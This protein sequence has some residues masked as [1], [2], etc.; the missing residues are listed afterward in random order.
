MLS[1]VLSMIII[2][3]VNMTYK[4]I[5][6]SILYIYIITGKSLWCMTSIPVH[7]VWQINTF[8]Y[9]YLYHRSLTDQRKLAAVIQYISFDS[10]HILSNMYIP[11]GAL[12][13]CKDRCPVTFCITR[14]G[15]FF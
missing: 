4:H 15:M 12:S 2:F 10:D 5:Q 1:L 7:I 6:A 3:L 8:V 9:V 13:E 11:Q 14:S